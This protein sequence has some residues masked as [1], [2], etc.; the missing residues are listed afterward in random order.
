MSQ[1]VV[2]VTG[3]STGIGVD[4]AKVFGKAGYIVIATGRRKSRLVSVVNELKFA[5]CEA[6]ALRRPEA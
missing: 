5:D 2:W 4:I 6:S 3:A 1:R